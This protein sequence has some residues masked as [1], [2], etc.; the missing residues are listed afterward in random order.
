[1]PI[2]SDYHLH[3]PLCHHATGP[4]EAYLERAIELGLGE[5]GFA[6]HNPLPDNL[7]ADV[8]M[9]ESD[10]E[11]YVQRVRDL[12][13]QYHGRID[14]LLGLEM[15][16]VPHL[17]D[18]LARQVAQYPWDYIIGSIHYLDPAC[19]LGAWSRHLPFDADEHYV[20]YYQLVRQLARSGLCDIIGHLDVAKRS[21]Q[22][23]GPRGLAELHEALADIAAADR[24]LEVNTSGY[25]HT[26]VVVPEPYPALPIVE[27]ALARGIPLVVN[28]DAHAP[29]CVGM[30]FAEMREALTRRGCRQLARFAQRK[31]ECCPLSG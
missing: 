25:R 4:M 5:V 13:F 8:R 27:E 9:R 26:D 22:F 15:D 28:S 20:R 10:L 3:T 30:M 18:Y 7:G 16:Y 11:Y 1:M 29:E 19:R 31:R 2:T 24:C 6:C 23:P 21:G 12:Q 14:V 17:A